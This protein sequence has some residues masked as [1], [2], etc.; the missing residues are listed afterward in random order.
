VE[1]TKTMGMAFGRLA[2]LLVAALLAG[3][4][5]TTQLRSEWVAPD[6]KAQPLAKIAV[7]VIAPDKEKSRLAAATIASRLGPRATSGHLVLATEETG[8]KPLDKARIEDLL[9]QKAFDGAIT[10]RLIAVEDKQQYVPPMLVTAPAANL[11][12]YRPRTGFYGYYRQSYEQAYLT[13]GYYENTREVVVES[14]VY[15]LSHNEAIWTGVTET[16]DPESMLAAAED[17][18]TEISKALTAAGI[19]LK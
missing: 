12:G 13:S 5:S 8:E 16:R 19:L 10:V 7:F 18:G 14:T 9:R 2:L 4:A 17:I 1:K 15:A 11:Q 6:A 3:C